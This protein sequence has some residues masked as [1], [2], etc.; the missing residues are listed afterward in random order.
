MGTETGVLQCQGASEEG[1][2]RGGGRGGE[3]G[4]YDVPHPRDPGVLPA[5]Q[6]E[7][8]IQVCNHVVFF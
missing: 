3:G 8:A 2:R 5:K 1:G 7:P 4:W 6:R